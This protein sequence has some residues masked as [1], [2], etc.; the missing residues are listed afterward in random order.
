MHEAKAGVI[1]LSFHDD[2]HGFAISRPACP[3]GYAIKA[4]A[5]TY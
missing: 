4:I 2:G 1:R 3:V 5:A